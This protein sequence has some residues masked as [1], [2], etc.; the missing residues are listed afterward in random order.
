MR[1]THVMAI[2]FIS[3]VSAAGLTH[4]LAGPN[5][6]P[7]ALMAEATHGKSHDQASGHSAPHRSG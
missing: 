7:P 4:A 2:S 3:V 6:M 1:R 5:T